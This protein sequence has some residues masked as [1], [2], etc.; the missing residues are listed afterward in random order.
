M[1]KKTR[2]IAF[3]LIIGLGVLW[4]SFSGLAATKPIHTVNIKINSDLQPGSHLPSIHI[5]SGSAPDGGIMV[6]KGNS[7][8]TVTAAQWLD[9]GSSY[10]LEAAS[11]PQMRVTLEPE[12]VSEYYF[13]ASYKESNVKISGGSFVSAR[14]DGD[15]LLVTLRVRPV[16]GEFNPPKDVYWNENNLGEARWTAPENDSGCYELQL[17]RDNKNVYRV[18][19]TTS[20]SYNFY[21]YM[22]EKGDYTFKV[23]TIPKT[24][25]Q[26]KYGSKSDYVES[27]ELQI[28]DRYVSDGKGQQKNG[29]AAVSGT[30]EKVGWFRDENGWRYRYPDG[31]LCRSKW[32]EIDGLWYY[33]DEN[34]RMMTGWQNIGGSS[35]Y[36]HGNGQMAVG[37]TK[38]DGKWYYLR[39]ETEDGRYPAGSMVSGGWRVIGP[40]YY[41]F[42][43]DGSLYTGWLK[44]GGK[45]Y[46]LNTVD[47]SLQG[48]MFTGWI[49]RDGKT[50]F[51]DSNG[52]ML[53]G[54]SQI[55]GSWY[56]FYPGSG[57]M[58]FS[59]WVDGAYLD[60]DG[61][62]RQ[63]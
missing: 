13:L 32:S 37:W 51:T 59:T 28:T 38:I 30:R 45:W 49:K 36:L 40:Y 18:S 42:N 15:N 55:D 58:A 39:T 54:W 24:D 2:C 46:Y 4:T 53:E 43:E 9:K 47:N 10:V 61:I 31:S 27:G 63:Q 6:D 41:Y 50:Y 60:A 8:Y 17:L 20:R 35:Y 48:A 5:G 21:P 33:F 22:T 52:E 62:W 3:V 56:Y 23:R 1:G 11:E 44:Y 7:R 25:A 19:Q 16:K 26:K 14:R 34:G 57:E 12:D 29:A